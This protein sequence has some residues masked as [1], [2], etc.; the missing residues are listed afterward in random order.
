MVADLITKEQ[1]DACME[2]V[3]A[4]FADASPNIET[5]TGATANSAGASGTVP[6]PAAGDHEKFLRGDGTWAEPSGGGNA[7]FSEEALAR[8]NDAFEE[9]HDF[10]ARYAGAPF[11]ADDIF[12]LDLSH[13]VPDISQIP[14]KTAVSPFGEGNITGL[15]LSTLVDGTNFEYGEN[16]SCIQNGSASYHVNNGISRGYVRIDTPK[17]CS[18]MLTVR[19]GVSSQ[20]SYDYGGCI[21]TEDEPNTAFSLSDLKASAT[22]M[23]IA[24]TVNATDYTRILKADKTYYLN[25]GYA[26]N[27]STNTGDDRFYIYSINAVPLAD[28]EYGPNKEYI[29]SGPASYHVNNGISRGYIK[30]DPFPVT[31]ELTV[32]ARI[33]SQASSDYG[34]CI[35]T[36]D[37][38]EP[39]LTKEKLKASD[40]MA[41]SGNTSSE[42]TTFKTELYP[43]KTYYLNFGYAKDASTNTGDDRFYLY[44]VRLNPVVTGESKYDVAANM[45]FT[46]SGKLADAVTTGLAGKMISANTSKMVIENK[47]EFNELENKYMSLLKKNSAANNL[48]SYYDNSIV[49]YQGTDCETTISIDSIYSSNEL[50]YTD[51]WGYSCTFSYTT[52]CKL[53]SS[54]N[55]STA[56]LTADS[57]QNYINYNYG[58]VKLSD[59]VGLII[60]EGIYAKTQ[61]FAA[62]TVQPF[63]VGSSGTI[64]LGTSIT[65][66]E[67]NSSN[68]ARDLRMTAI[69]SMTDDKTITFYSVKEAY[70]SFSASVGYSSGWTEKHSFITICFSMMGSGATTVDSLT[71]IG[72]YD[73]ESMS[74]QFQADGQ[75]RI[76]ISSCKRTGEKIRVYYKSYRPFTTVRRD[77]NSPLLYCETIKYSA[78]SE[79]YYSILTSVTAKEYH[80]HGI[81]RTAVKIR[82]VPITISDNSCEYPENYAWSLGSIAIAKDRRDGSLYMISFSGQNRKAGNGFYEYPYT[83]DWYDH[84]FNVFKIA[85]NIPD[86]KSVD[87]KFSE[88]IDYLVA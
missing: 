85:P 42:I 35:I 36:E 9:T 43:N 88:I 41:L 68:T 66:T 7:D 59:C 83:P 48:V 75:S 3:S 55:G 86:I 38:P 70:K 50:A 82:N 30:I 21:I 62:V 31:T 16:N 44:S 78:D 13:L 6:Q 8:I 25:F 69:Y 74:T 79:G 57:T 81:Y 61:G 19:A 84:V 72:T 40:F 28:F 37:E 47:N 45:V 63:S 17:D 15:D 32:R 52:S 58:L 53:V 12:K 64:S 51:K 18:M 24:G 54:L 56:S 5:M 71:A 76:I 65:V 49:F 26:K 4:H 27:A 60:R 20:A 22:W 34:G 14:S 77:K 33:S 73:S 2:R 1:L 23:K 46:Y 10:E 29:Q 80:F 67:D 39:D 11:G 87:I